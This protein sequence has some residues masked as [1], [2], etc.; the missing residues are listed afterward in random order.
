MSLIKISFFF[1]GG[2]KEHV[3]YNTIVYYSAFTKQKIT[4]IVTKWVNLEDILSEINPE[5]KDKCSI[6]SFSYGIS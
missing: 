5:Q 1:K 4:V 2:R 6:M 3:V